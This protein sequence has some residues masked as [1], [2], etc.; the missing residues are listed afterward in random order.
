MPHQLRRELRQH[1]IFAGDS[2]SCRS[3]LEILRVL[4][5]GGRAPDGHVLQSHHGHLLQFLQGDAEIVQRRVDDR[6]R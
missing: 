1:R 5:C 2:G 6:G 3:V 4:I